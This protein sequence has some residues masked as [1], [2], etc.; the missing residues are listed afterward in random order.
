[1]AHL[2]KLLVF[3]FGRKP[4]KGKEYEIFFIYS[5]SGI[6]YEPFL[7]LDAP[8]DAHFAVFPAGVGEA[9]EASLSGADE[10]VEDVE[11]VAKFV[12]CRG[13]ARPQNHNKRFPQYQATQAGTF[14]KTSCQLQAGQE[15][16]QASQ[17]NGWLGCRIKTNGF[18]LSIAVEFFQARKLRFLKNT[19]NTTRQRRISRRT[20]WFIWKNS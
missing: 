17:A 8:I 1:L 4:I 15:A 2:E 18:W 13:Q 7:L 16:A 6:L 9:D 11:D 5:F 20:F 14:E 12:L 3:P 19:F 10:D